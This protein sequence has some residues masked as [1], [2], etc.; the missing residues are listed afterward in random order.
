MMIC[1]TLLGSSWLPRYDMGTPYI[2]R[3][4]GENMLK[5][6]ALDAT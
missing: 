5:P 4:L 1:H 6:I 2:T 3:V